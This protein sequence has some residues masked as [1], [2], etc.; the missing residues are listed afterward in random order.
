M[1]DLSGLSDAAVD[2]EVLL[3]AEALH[4][5]YP[6]PRQRLFGPWPVRHALRGVGLELAE[7]GSIGIV[8]ESGSGK[9]TLVRLLLALDRADSGTVTY[10][11]RPVSPGRPRTLRWFRREV[12][13]VP[14]DPFTSLDPRMR[15]ADILAEPLECLDVPGDHAALVTELLGAVGLIAATA[16]DRYPHEFSGGQRQR[17]A[18]ARALA[19]GPRVLVGDEPLS[20]LDV[21]VRE[22]VMDLLRGLATDLGLAL[23]LVSHDIGVVH[24][25]CEQIVVLHEGVIV[26]RGRTADVLASPADP[27]TR[28]LLA[29]V[30]QLPERETV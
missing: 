17:I 30:P 9:S 26:E 23:V 7:G 22:Q 19:P 12:Q 1:S 10:R 15:V 13:M 29:A 28:R 3:R 14:Q 20:A 27:Y 11:G 25:L 5:T 16:K 21:T 2:R 8:G 4:R 6:L 24:R 18:I